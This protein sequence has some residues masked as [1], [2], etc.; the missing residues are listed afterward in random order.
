MAAGRAQ[1]ALRGSGARG[2]GR[3]GTSPR[4]RSG[5]RGP[6]LPLAGFQVRIACPWPMSDHHF[7]EEARQYLTMLHRRKGLVLTCALVSLLTAA[8]YNYTARPLYQATAQLLIEPTRANVLPGRD[9]RGR[10]SHGRGFLPDPVRAAARP[11][12]ARE[13]DR[14]AGP[15]AVGRAPG[16]SSALA[17]AGP[18]RAS[19]PDHSGRGRERALP[20]SPAV[21]A[22]RS[23]LTIEPLPG[24][25]LVNLRFSAYDPELAAQGARTPWPRP[26]SSSSSSSGSPPPPR[27]R[28][29]CPSGWASRQKRLQEAETALQSLPREGGSGGGGRDPGPPRPEAAE[30]HRRPHGGPHRSHREG[31][32]GQED[33]RPARGRAP[34]LPQGRGEPA[35]AV[36][37]GARGRGPRGGGPARGLPGREASRPAAAA[38]AHREPRRADRGGGAGHRP[39]GGERLRDG[40]PAGGVAGGRAGGG[41]ARGPA[42]EPQGDGAR[43][44][45]PRGGA[46]PEAA[47]RPRD[48]HPGDRPRDPAPRHE[49]AH[50]G[51]G[52]GAAGAHPSPQ[53]PELP[54]RPGSSASPSGSGSPS[55]SSA[56]TTR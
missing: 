36:A 1:S 49:P 40:A 9:G 39:H 28:A 13:G 34:D 42:G 17:P 32:R 46:G 11:G 19:G 44:A 2:R 55:C 21:E 4:S 6:T 30:P 51:E 48:P 50:R 37:A 52:L 31:G 24:S 45:A 7:L 10:R 14:P 53:D 15:A 54:A 35:R 38:G 18:A 27:P 8:L 41:Q 26:S 33:A 3:P 47:A 29:G 12:P 22:F 56:W 5:L 23:R 16:R 25:R 20:V 43:V